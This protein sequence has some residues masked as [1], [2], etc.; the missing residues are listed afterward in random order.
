MSQDLA[1]TTGTLIIA[2]Q[3]TTQ[4]EFNAPG[5]PS[6]ATDLVLMDPP[7]GHLAQC[8]VGD[9]LRLTAHAFED[10]ATATVAVN[11]AHKFWLPGG[12]P[13][14]ALCDVWLTVTAV[15][16][17]GTHFQYTVQQQAGPACRFPAG[18][19]VTNYGQPEQAT[20]RL[21]GAGADAP[22][23]TIAD[24]GATPWEATTTRVQV[25]ALSPDDAGE[26]TT[27][28]VAVGENLDDAASSRTV[29]DQSGLTLAGTQLRART[30]A[31][32]TAQLQATGDLRVGAD[33]TDEAST[34]LHVHPTTQTVTTQN[35]TIKG[36]LSQQGEATFLG[37]VAVVQD[38]RISA[39]VLP[40]GDVRLGTDITQPEQTAFHYQA[41][42]NNLL[43][44]ASTYLV[45]NVNIDGDITTTDGDHV[46]ARLDRTGLFKLGPD[47]DQPDGTRLFY[48]PATQTLA[49]TAP[50]RLAG[51]LQTN[52]AITVGSDA[53]RLT[54]FGKDGQVEFGAN[55]PTPD[56]VYSTSARTVRIN[57]PLT[58]TADATLD[59]TLHVGDQ[60]GVVFGHDDSVQI[61]REG[62]TMRLLPGEQNSIKVLGIGRAAL[63]NAYQSADST[64][65]FDLLGYYNSG[66]PSLHGRVQLG[67]D[68]AS[69]GETDLY[70][71]LT[72]YFTGARNV[73]IRA[74]FVDIESERAQFR[75]NV[76][77][78]GG[79]EFSGDQGSRTFRLRNLPVN[80]DGLP[81]GAV[82]N[83]GGTLR[84]VI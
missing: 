60:G 11:I 25:G 21:I 28:G 23:V 71:R 64:Q 77:V 42:Q 69:G 1:A 22:Q 39:Q 27:L 79:F 10:P 54:Y 74:S 26:A 48:D 5:V 63:L 46:T 33:V 16:D 82:W 68:N 45:G 2:P 58:V 40:G 43:L 24:N 56:F 78:R 36:A 67:V 81:Q 75:G 73:E 4:V 13:A 8:V 6:A 47:V 20:L 61:N 62:L 44:R 14:T 50:V 12:L 76:N 18:T 29:I 31:T 7:T 83:D 34:T 53:N 65:H 3:G 57:V 55:N 84:I 52:G 32:T 37:A 35:V 51:D 17:Q 30:G 66:V 38:G 80:P 72:R 70:L 9:F 59:G 49:V 15:S 41:E 19:P